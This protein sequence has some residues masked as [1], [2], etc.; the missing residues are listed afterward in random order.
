MRRTGFLLLTVLLVLS[1][2]KEK[3]NQIPNVLVDEYV[4]L[5]NPQYNALSAPGG[6]V[7]LNGGYRG[8]IVYRRSN[9]EFTAFDRACT[10]QPSESC[11]V[12]AVDSSGVTATD[13]CCG[14]RFQIT[15]GSVIKGPATRALKS[16]KTYFD[17]TVVRITN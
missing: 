11:E 8:I 14:S 9:D 5:N 17:G 10:N 2:K 13:A 16:Y 15:D 7:Y 1:C 3:Q 12:I 6:W 4:Y